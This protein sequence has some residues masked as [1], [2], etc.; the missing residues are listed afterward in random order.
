MSVSDAYES[1]DDEVVG[2]SGTI[3]R[4]IGS[5]PVDNVNW[6]V[7]LRRLLFGTDSAEWALR[8]SSDDEPLTPTNASPK[9]YS[10]Q[11]GATVTAAKVDGSGIFVQ[12]GGSR[13]MESSSTNDFDYSTSDLTLLF[14]EAGSSP[15][16]RMGV[17]RQPDTRIHC[18]RQDGIAAILIHDPV[19]NIT[20]WTMHETGD[21]AVTVAG[22]DS[23]GETAASIDGEGVVT[24]V[25]NSGYKSTTASFTSV[26][27]EDVVVLPGGDGTSEDSVYY[28]VNRTVNGGTV[29]YIEKWSLESECQGGTINKCVDSHVVGTI[30]GGVMTGLTHLEGLQVSVWVNGKDIG[31]ATVASGQ[32]TG[33]SEDGSNACAGVS[34][35]A[36]FKSAKLGELTE[37]KNI[38]RL[39]VILNNTHYQG[40]LYG[41][42]FMGGHLDN[43]PLTEDGS[44][45]AADTVHSA[46]DKESFS[47]DGRWDTDSRLCMQAQ[48]PRPVTCLAA[49]IETES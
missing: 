17:Q 3:R 29:R 6:L 7:P 47:F 28:V 31:V 49:I 12:R 35:T 8:S 21:G 46:Y 20:C 45:T 39:G 27:I 44:T 19:E 11:G 14:P 1:F 36:R 13:V 26:L 30:T 2:D 18:I 48:S 5:G 25:D 24:Y 42:D 32:I 40:L 23:W 41:P 34:Y 15:I 4:T 9:S 10:T 37:K 22:T 43:L 33:L 38:T 16:Q